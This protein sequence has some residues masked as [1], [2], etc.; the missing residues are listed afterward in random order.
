MNATGEIPLYNT[1]E[2]IPI[3]YIYIKFPFYMNGA[4]EIPF[5]MTLKKIPTRKFPQ[6]DE[7]IIFIHILLSG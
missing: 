6:Y 7:L 1:I 2:N 3:C 4:G 5:I